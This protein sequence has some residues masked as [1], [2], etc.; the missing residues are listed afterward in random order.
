MIMV[1]PLGYGNSGGPGGAM[2]ADMI[3]SYARTVVEE[4]MPQVEKNYNVTKDRTQR[5]IAGLSMGGAEAT[6]VG[7]QP[8]RQVRLDRLLQRRL[9]HVAGSSRTRARGPRDTWSRA[10]GTG[11]GRGAPPSTRQLCPRTSPT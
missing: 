7:L 9:R 5:A 11:G 8:P 3:P 1:T 6:F 2:S 10:C 4:V